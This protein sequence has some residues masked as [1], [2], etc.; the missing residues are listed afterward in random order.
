MNEI[1]NVDE[2]NF[3]LKTTISI[4]RARLWLLLAGLLVG[5]GIGLLVSITI[6]PVYEAT[7]KILVTRSDQQS[8]SDVTAYL[9]DLQLAQTYL[10]LLTTQTVLDI[11]SDRTDVEFEPEDIKTEVI[12]DTQVIQ[13]GVENTD[14][15]R[16]VLIANSMV[17]VLIEQNEVIQSA[18]YKTMEESLKAQKTQIEKEI[19]NLQLQ[20]ESVTLQGVAEQKLWIESSISSLQAEKLTLQQEIE[21][22]NTASTEADE[23]LL[24]QKNT[25]LEQIQSLLPLYES[26]YNKLLLVYGSPLEQQIDLA[27]SRLALLNTTQALYEQYYVSIL[28]EL[29]SVHLARL[30]NAPNIVQIETASIPEEPIRPLPW[31]YTALG[32]IIG[33]VCMIGVVF[34]REAL[35]DTVKSKESIE[36]LLGVPVIGSIGEMPRKQKDIRKIHISQQPHSIISEDFRL[37]RTNLEMDL[38]RK[39][40]HTILVTSPQDAEGKTT[41]ATNL[42]ASLAQAEKRV[43][44]LEANMRRLELQT[45]TGSASPVGL[46]TLL[47]DPTNVQSATCSIPDLPHL[48]IIRAGEAPS[49][50]A[51]LLSSNKMRHVL[52]ALKELADVV[53]IDSPPSFVADAQ[54]LARD[55]D[56]VILVVRPGI[57]PV[58]AARNSIEMFK[59]VGIHVMGIVMN[60]VSVKQ[61]YDRSRK[62]YLAAN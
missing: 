4:F 35:D 10:Q 59:R 30:Q 17:D 56:A 28:G 14:P 61:G 12:R 1:E 54:I 20:I 32:A 47:A 3:D 41:V 24:D 16:A 43:V 11:V 8:S 36:Q 26:N 18:R 2:L 62:E 60:R 44:L 46:S 21:E 58:E 19:Q 49:N 25:R 50:P 29:E 51:E 7:T 52:N 9:S 48:T 6:D 22:L 57:T 39:S 23:L 45:E 13:I 38:A 40:I 33:L 34:L 27:D 15:R 42:A 55:A 53:V 31:L 37:L 5:A